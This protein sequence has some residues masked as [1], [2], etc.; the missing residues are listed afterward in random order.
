MPTQNAYSVRQIQIKV[1]SLTFVTE[2]HPK[3]KYIVYDSEDPDSDADYKQHDGL[4]EDCINKILDS[5]PSL[6]GRL[7]LIQETNFL[8]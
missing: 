1:T 4:V 8:L 2:R 5:N 3:T 6:L 7:G